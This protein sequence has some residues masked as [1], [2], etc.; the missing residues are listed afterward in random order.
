MPEHLHTK[1][2][3]LTSAAKLLT[4][5]WWWPP[6][7]TMSSTRPVDVK[8]Y[9]HRVQVVME[10]CHSDYICAQSASLAINRVPRVP[11]IFRR[12]CNFTSQ[13]LL[14]RDAHSQPMWCT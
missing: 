13:P 1:L 5:A 7:P 11:Q 4:P 8:L 12:Q 6:T 9:S 2:L 3:R 10:G 14:G